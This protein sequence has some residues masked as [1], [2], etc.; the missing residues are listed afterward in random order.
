MV[1]QQGDR[2]WNGTNVLIDINPFITHSTHERLYHTTGV[3]AP[4]FLASSFTSHKN[5][6][7]ERAERWGLPFIVLIREDK[8]V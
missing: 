6:N 8:N 4:Y 1:T 5:Q 7:N 2:G 3:Y